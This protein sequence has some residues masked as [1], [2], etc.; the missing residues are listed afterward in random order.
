[1]VHGEEDE[2][3][4]KPDQETDASRERAPL[5]SVAIISID[6]VMC[7][8]TPLEPQEYARNMQADSV[9]SRVEVPVLRI[10][11]PLIRRDSTARHPSRLVQEPHQSACLY[12]HGAFPY[13]L[14]RP[15]VA[16]PDGSI[17]KGTHQLF[18]KKKST[19]ANSS[20]DDDDEEDDEDEAY[21]DW[22]E[23][24]AVRRLVPLI[25][26]DLES[27]VQAS[28]SGGWA[29]KSDKPAALP[30]KPVKPVIRSITVVMGRG[31]YTYCPGPV[32]PFLRIEYYDPS[33]K[34]RIKAALNRG[35]GQVP[36]RCHPDPRQYQSCRTDLKPSTT[37]TGRGEN[38]PLKF[39]CYEA[40]I[41]Y[42][43]Q[44][45]KDNNLAGSSYLHL[46]SCL[47]RE[48]PAKPVRKWI[49]QELPDE[50]LVFLQSNTPFAVMWNPLDHG[51]VSVVK[52]SN[53]AEE[54]P[55][56][57]TC[58]NLESSPPL[59]S[60]PRLNSKSTAARPILPSFAPD[61]S[62]FSKKLTSCDVELDAVVGNILNVFDVMKDVKDEDRLQTH[63]R[64]V[65]SLREIW[66]EE[67][68]RMSKL[69][70]PK[71][72]F[73]SHQS[74]SDADNNDAALPDVFTLSVKKGAPLPGAKLAR[75]GMQRLVQVSEG[76]EED[77]RRA[78]TDVA[79]RY[80]DEV[81][82]IDD[83]LRARH[84]A[85][86]VR[87]GF[88]DQEKSSPTD[89]DFVRALE[90]LFDFE[91]EG[92]NSAQS[93][94]SHQ[95]QSSRVSTASERFMTCS[96]TYYSQS[97]CG[98]SPQLDDEIEFSQRV[99]RGESVFDGPFEHVEDF[100][101][102]MTLRP[103]E[104]IEEEDAYEDVESD[105]EMS[106]ANGHDD[107]E[108]KLA[109]KLSAFATQTLEY[110]DL[111]EASDLNVAT[112]T[113]LSFD[114][115]SSLDTLYD[116]NVLQASDHDD[117]NVISHP[118][119]AEPAVNVSTHRW[120]H[121]AN[122]II[123]LR[124]APPTR[125]DFTGP[126]SNALLPM[127][128]DQAQPSWMK[129]SFAYHEIRN[130]AYN[131]FERLFPSMNLKGSVVC[132]NRTAP[133]RHA[134]DAWYRRQL[135]R[136][137]TAVPEP[138]HKRFK[139]NPRARVDENSRKLVYDTEVEEVEWH[140]SQ[141]G[142]SQTQQSQ[143]G[144]EKFLEQVDAEL[145]T[146]C[147]ASQDSGLGSSQTL[148]KTPTSSNC[149]DSPS[150]PLQ[151]MGNQG[152]RMYLEGGGQL[153]AKTRPS[154]GLLSVPALTSLTQ[155]GTPSSP[156][157][158]NPISL[159]SIEIH[160]QCRIGGTDSRRLAMTPSADRD[161]VVAVVYI[162]A[163]DPG[164]GESLQVLER[165][166]V[167]VPSERE[168]LA[169]SAHA[170]G[171]SIRSS[172]PTEVLGYASPIAIDCVQ[173]EQRLLLRL[174]SIVRRKDPDFLFSWDTQASG[175]GYLVERGSTLGTD[176]PSSGHSKSQP[177]AGIDMARLL[178]RTPT[179]LS[180][181]LSTAGLFNCVDDSKS[182]FAGEQGS[183]KNDENVWRGS[184][185]GAA[186]DDRVGAGAAA[187][188]IVRRYSILVRLL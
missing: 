22:D 138:E 80:Q 156:Y 148:S 113:N 131:D 59:L 129:H 26:D 142:T 66:N 139:T 63:W 78:M 41:S 28:I 55:S 10:F 61:G 7:E 49:Q 86:Q 12:I 145:G 38:D 9:K 75:E 43:M 180:S 84:E 62:S 14:A 81:D 109:R 141:T 140:L 106:E 54:E 53:E 184:R 181:H 104:A 17:H 118:L 2:T 100:I 183:E 111:S 60:P 132:L 150:V 67:R 47:F 108:Q 165:G 6:H 164:G 136:S 70:S 151:G 13:L 160:V 31:F 175:I 119:S 182:S 37:G 32:A 4:V 127:Q 168:L 52:N 169:T 30:P 76:L 122:A 121:E 16:G 137:C 105:N 188:S 21:T 29:N 155:Q 171:E 88:K 98:R 96:Q 115:S 134:V 158:A 157:L 147:S 85:T 24:E 89:T 69:L 5:C 79:L 19:D 128:I 143:T 186:W 133:T 159:M 124:D 173:D 178:G 44:F 68:R 91:P 101:D 152:G 99:D 18:A 46:N 56:H 3:S 187:A 1:M 36:L 123:R 50:S 174:G 42:S 120:V 35:L 64:A 117:G 71:D 107:L 87:V 162:F 65:P 144:N 125:N 102:P 153:K 8:P 170:L 39:H 93:Q 176:G 23:M 154:Q 114:D 112:R 146:G 57:S 25:Q 163:R 40:H 94:A 74:A 95:S 20:D 45:F 51:S 72:D 166:C 172:L 82:D 34:F 73:L 126:G 185:L 15:V 77:L 27:T 48:L 167:F 116:S 11:G 58:D 149:F 92:V 33:N 110:G 135:K 97:R 83:A 130:P 177:N 161:R 103:F 90:D 179:S